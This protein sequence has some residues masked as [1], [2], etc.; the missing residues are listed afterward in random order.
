MSP[1]HQLIALRTLVEKEVRRFTRIWA[2]TIL[3]AAVTVALY[4]CLGN[5]SARIGEWTVMRN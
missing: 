4:F 3:P 5:S 2:Q 1:L